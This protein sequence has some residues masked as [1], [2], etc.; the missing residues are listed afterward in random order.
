MSETHRREFVRTLALGAS[1]GLVVTASSVAG[2]PTAQEK[3]KTAQDDKPKDDKPKEEPPR[4]EVDARMDLII[5]RY[6]KHLDEAA[7][8]I[9]RAEVQS[10]VRRAEALKRF[11]LTNGDEP[12]PVFKPYRAPLA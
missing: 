6:G 1:A 4:T 10:H 11:A 2:D 9:V 3:A 8:K 5:A 12:F 7:R